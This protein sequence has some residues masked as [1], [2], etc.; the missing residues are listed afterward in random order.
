MC[1]GR[2][3]GPN[4][5]LAYRH[6]VLTLLKELTFNLGPILTRRVNGG[7]A[8]ESYPLFDLNI[9]GGQSQC[10]VYGFGDEVTLTLYGLRSLLGD[11]VQEGVIYRFNVNNEEEVIEV[12]DLLRDLLGPY[13][14]KHLTRETEDEANSLFFSRV[15]AIKD[16]G[17]FRNRN[18]FRKEQVIGFFYL[19]AYLRV[20]Q[21]VIRRGKGRGRCYYHVTRTSLLGKETKTVIPCP[22]VVK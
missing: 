17:A 12:Q 16:A 7:F 10:T 22:D 15:S 1:D 14:I 8:E 11:N 9:N 6:H 2:S 13:F 20:E 21:V 4:M 5:D 19:D 18:W 3:R